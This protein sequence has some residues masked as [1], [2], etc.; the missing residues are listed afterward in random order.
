MCQSLHVHQ[1]YY[2]STIRGTVF[3]III[4]Q[5]LCVY[6]FLLEVGLVDALYGQVKTLMAISSKP[7]KDMSISVSVRSAVDILLLAPGGCC[8][9]F[10]R[11]EYIGDRQFVFIEGAKLKED[12]NMQY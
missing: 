12:L 8:C 2:E 11:V 4:I 9:W 3:G 5:K 10:E 7:I 1:S 6:V